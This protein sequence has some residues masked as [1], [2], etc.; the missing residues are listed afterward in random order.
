MFGVIHWPEGFKKLQEAGIVPKNTR[1]FV[2]D[3]G[4]PDGVA[5]IYYDAYPR[6]EDFDALVDFL[7]S[8]KQRNE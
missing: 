8:A 7:L 3:S 6:P 4:P 5:K 2:L 1:R